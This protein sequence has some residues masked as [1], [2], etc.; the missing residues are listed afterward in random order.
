MYRRDFLRVAGVGGAAFA[1][2]AAAASAAHF[3]YGAKCQSASSVGTAP[4]PSKSES[5]PAREKM[6]GNLFFKDKSDLVLENFSLTGRLQLVDCPGAIIRNFDISGIVDNKWGNL[7]LDN[8]PGAVIEDGESHSNPRGH[9]LFVK[10]DMNGVV[11]RRFEAYGCEEDGFQ[12]ANNAI[13]LIRFYDAHLHGND[14][15]AVDLKGGM[16]CFTGGRFQTN[17]G[18]HEP[19]I[20]QNFA[21]SIH[22]IDALIVDNPQSGRDKALAAIFEGKGIFENC[23]YEIRRDEKWFRADDKTQYDLQDLGTPFNLVTPSLT[24]TGGKR[25]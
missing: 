2:G 15:N 20:T 7:S 5:L 25:V 21:E 1:A 18:N 22:M 14:E 13:G 11:V 12:S 3:S 24:V 23:Q 9:G 19:I 6:E 4:P 10:N 17:A 8:C 16:A